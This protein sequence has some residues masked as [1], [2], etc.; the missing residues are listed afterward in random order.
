MT[1]GSSAT[2]PSGEAA[3][4]RLRQEADG[5]WWWSYVE[6]GPGLE[7][8]GNRPFE[9]REAAIRSASA[10]YPEV[11]ILEDAASAEAPSARATR[12]FPVRALVIGL[13]V[14][15]AIVAVMWSRPSRE[16]RRSGLR[17]EPP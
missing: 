12:A 7:L 1:S 9:S 10:A 8:L 4:I 2:E 16:P 15:V 11:P 3:F 14:G 17:A 13:G 6:P 5:G